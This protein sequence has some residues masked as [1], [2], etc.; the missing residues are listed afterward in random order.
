[1]ADPVLRAPVVE[2]LAW[3]RGRLAELLS[4]GRERGELRP[5]LDP[6]TT[7]DTITAVL[8]GSWALARAAGSGEPFADAVDGI[9]AALAASPAAATAA[10]PVPRPG[11]DGR[12]GSR[13]GPPARRA[14]TRR[15]ARPG[16]RARWTG[17]RRTRASPG[18]YG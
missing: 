17:P 8:Q 2:A 12:R 11:S 14:G 7:A 15:P 16:C 13:P 18:P 4:Q 1:M 9:L 5:G 10:E 3:L 6:E